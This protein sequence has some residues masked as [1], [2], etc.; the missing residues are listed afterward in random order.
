MNYINSLKEFMYAI[1]IFIKM[2]TNSDFEE[3]TLPV[4]F[5]VPYIPPI[6][7]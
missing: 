1:K 6:G 2:A 5:T 4:D 3:V 7:T